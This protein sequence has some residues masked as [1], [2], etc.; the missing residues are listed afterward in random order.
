MTRFRYKNYHFEPYGK[1]P[2]KMGFYELSKRIRSDK[3][4]NFRN[5][6]DGDGWN[7][8][9]FYEKSSDKEADLFRCIENGKIYI[10]AE[11]E[12]FLFAR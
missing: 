7:Y 6:E 10:P 1:L 2:E 8:R 5:Y 11:N 9:E 4:L 3:S 12:L